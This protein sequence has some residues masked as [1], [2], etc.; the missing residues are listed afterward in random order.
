MIIIIIIIIIKFHRGQRWR[1]S[2]LTKAH[3]LTSPVNKTY[4]IHCNERI[5]FSYLL[6]PSQ[7]T[8]QPILMLSKSTKQ[9]FSQNWTW[10]V[11]KQILR[12][13]YLFCNR[14]AFDCNLAAICKIM[15]HTKLLLLFI[16]RMIMGILSDKKAKVKLLQAFNWLSS[17]F[18]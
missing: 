15:Y 4:L 8:S 14:F 13:I 5:V 3:L 9:N 11:M 7:S 17:S 1:N 2:A 6:K 18:L 16:Y 12:G 10:L